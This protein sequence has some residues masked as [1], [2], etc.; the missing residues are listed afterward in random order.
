[1]IRIKNMEHPICFDVQSNDGEVHNLIT[2]P[3]NSKLVY[4]IVLL[5]YIFISTKYCMPS[6]IINW[7]YAPI[8][9]N[10]MC[11]VEN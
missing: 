8:R 1:M 6:Y 2:D 3:R 7:H 4:I 10:N 11:K 9:I 5:T